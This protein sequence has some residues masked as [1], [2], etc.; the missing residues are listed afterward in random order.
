MAKKIKSKI[1]T[2]HSSF[3]SFIFG[4]ELIIL[5]ESLEEENSEVYE[6]KL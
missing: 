5:N 4:P 2:L 3:S 1:S 6:N